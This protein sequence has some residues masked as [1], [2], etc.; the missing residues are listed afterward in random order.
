[1]DEPK[2][3]KKER[4]YEA[5]IRVFVFSIYVVHDIDSYIFPYMLEKGEVKA[6]VSNSQSLDYS[7]YSPNI[8]APNSRQTHDL[9]PNHPSPFGF[10]TID[11]FVTSALACL[12]HCSL[13]LPC[14]FFFCFTVLP[15][16]LSLLLHAPSVLVY[17]VSFSWY[18]FSKFKRRLTRRRYEMLNK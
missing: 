12:F 6:F 16:A 5:S 7:L 8:Y 3:I 17:R 15:C 9:M 1:M 14:A 18:F 11:C 10:H 13:M 4:I 2:R